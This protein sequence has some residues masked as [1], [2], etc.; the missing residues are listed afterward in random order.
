MSDSVI[1]KFVLLGELEAL[2][3]LMVGTG[4][5]DVIDAVV[6]R[7]YEGN[8]PFIPATAL[9]G[10]LRHSLASKP[11]TTVER[12]FWGDTVGSDSGSQS[13]LAVSDLL[14]VVGVIPRIVVRD[15]IRID[16]TTGIV[17][18][19]AKFN[20]EV[21]EPGATFAVRLEATVR[22]WDGK[23][24]N[25]SEFESILCRIKSLCEAEGFSLGAMTTRGF[26][27]LKLKNARL[28]RYDFPADGAAWFAFLASA[29]PQEENRRNFKVDQT[30]PTPSVFSISAKLAIKSSLIIGSAPDT[31]DAPDKSHLQSNGAPVLSGTSLRG[32]MRSRA[33]RIAATLGGEQGV[34]LLNEVFGWVDPDNGKKAVRSTPLKSRISID[35]SVIKN[36][37]PAVQSRIRI[38]RFTGGVAHG[39]LFDSMPLW[40]SGESE[41]SVKVR[42]GDFTPGADD[43]IAGLLLQLLKDL[44]NGDLP[45]GGE[46]SIGRGVL[47][48]KSAEVS[49]CGRSVGIVQKGGETVIDPGGRDE[50]NRLAAAFA[51]KMEG[52]R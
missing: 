2:S 5:G 28:F 8:L 30:T 45:V 41:V 46:K 48:G 26:G 12:Y 19:G 13:H 43:W 10:V 27:R 47:A 18:D 11:R 32:A 22:G 37:V 31:P 4:S 33:E 7:G 42:L 39:A 20:F 49:W 6:L 17:A 25:A 50:L 38:D 23:E 14:P 15:G 1:A 29:T 36:V 34:E 9:A 40:N 44:W 21:V 52:C 35:E 16:S 24:E 3:P 51:G